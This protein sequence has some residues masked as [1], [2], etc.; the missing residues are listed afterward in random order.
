M[1]YNWVTPGR[2]T[3]CHLRIAERLAQGYGE[4]TSD[5]AAE[6][7]L[8][9]ERGGDL[10]RAVH[11]LQ[12]AAEQASQRLARQEGVNHLTK[13][14]DLLRTFTDPTERTELELKCQIS[15]GVALTAITGYAAPEVKQAYD[16]ARELCQQIDKTPQLAPVLR[17]LAA[18]YYTRAELATARELAEQL[19]VSVQA[20]DDESLLMEAHFSL[21]GT[22]SSQGEFIS[23]LHHLDLARS[24][25]DPQKHYSHALLYG[26]DPGV[27]SLC[28][29]SQ[30]L[31]F[32]GYPDQALA[33][34]QESVVRARELA[35]PHSLAYALTFATLLRQLRREP[36][37]IE[38]QTKEIIAVATEHGFPIWKRMGEMFQGWSITTLGNPQEGIALL[39][40]GISTWRTIGAKVS[41]PY[42]LSLLAEAYRGT[43]NFQKGIDVLDEAF[44][45]VVI[46]DDRLWEAEL[47]RLKGEFLLQEQ[48]Q[49]I[50]AP[51]LEE[52]PK[53]NS[54]RRTMPRTNAL[55]LVP[56]E[57]TEKMR[58]TIYSG[59]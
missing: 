7:A 34:G 32:L 54:K 4:Q 25:Y 21:G 6:L 22:L 45:L 29:A 59:R 56:R 53:A 28:R 16:R 44:S 17:G 26:Q 10:R 3:Q 1:F 42:Y 30:M 46:T 36:W 8:H 15:L 48:G 12:Q 9:F 23:A 40:Q 14:L 20:R 49:E 50:T 43:R 11:C 37:V 51:S 31:W 47:Y 52:I 57:T 5:V 41:L 58:R 33:K 2:R 27:A 19:L 24:L 38:S 13:A 55:L 39:Q 18:F 35:H